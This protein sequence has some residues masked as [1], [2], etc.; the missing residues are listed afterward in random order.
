MSSKLS[1]IFKPLPIEG[2]RFGLTNGL[3]N[4]IK[5]LFYS[6][7]DFEEKVDYKFQGVNF[8]CNRMKIDLENILSQE[9]IQVS[10]TDKGF[11]LIKGNFVSEYEVL[12]SGKLSENS[13][14]VWLKSENQES[15]NR[16]STNGL[17]N[18]RQGDKIEMDVEFKTFVDLDDSNLSNKVSMKNPLKVN[19]LARESTNIDIR[20]SKFYFLKDEED[21]RFFYRVGDLVY[22]QLQRGIFGN[23]FY[24]ASTY[25]K[26]LD[27]NRFLMEIT[28]RDNL[29]VNARI[30][31]E[32]NLVYDGNIETYGKIPI[33]Y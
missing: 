2:V 14:L 25:H 7:E 30:K 28:E 17:I 3:I 5:N 9:H 18:L 13:Q 24:K 22:S 11:F 21:E 8:L 33:Y 1:D 29:S 31:R 15:L 10:E 4:Q 23:H 32:N 27:E 19:K 26:N 16:F 6:K 12:S 20:F